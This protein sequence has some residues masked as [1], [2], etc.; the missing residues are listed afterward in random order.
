[1]DLSGACLGVSGS[2][3]PR[4]T[5]AVCCRMSE[6]AAFAVSAKDCGVIVCVWSC[7][8]SRARVDETVATFLASVDVKTSLVCGSFRRLEW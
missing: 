5:C 3:F 1:M 8:V 2:T 6:S 4:T 7:A